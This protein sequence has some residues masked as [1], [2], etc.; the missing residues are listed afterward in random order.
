MAIQADRSAGSGEGP[1]VSLGVPWSS[2]RF[3]I[4]LLLLLSALNGMV[5]AA[6]VVALAATLSA[7]PVPEGEQAA[8]AALSSLTPL[9][10]ELVDGEAEV[11]DLSPLL[12]DLGEQLFALEDEGQDALVAMAAYRD[13]LDRAVLTGDFGEAAAGTRLNQRYHQLV[14]AVQMLGDGDEAPSLE[15][16]ARTLLL[17]LFGWLVLGAGITVAAS[18]RLRRVLSVPLSGLS[19]AAMAVADG[20]LDHSIP[21]TTESQEFQQLGAALETMR[22]GLVRTIAELDEQNA[23]SEAMLATLSDGVLL[24]DR[25]RR[26]LE[27]NPAAARV[28]QGVAPP[29]LARTRNLPVSELLPGLDRELFAGRQGDPVQLKYTGPG[30]THTHLEVSLRPLA[31][32][33]KEPGS[34]FVMVVRDVTRAVEVENLKRGFLSVVTHELKTPLTVIEGYVRLLQMGKGGDLSPKQAQMLQKVRSQAEIL[35]MMV[36]DLLDATR[37]EG[38]HLT[39]DLGQVV[40]SRVVVDTAESL[41]PEAISK[42]LKLLLVDDAPSGVVIH[43][44]EFRF[45]QVL[46]NLLRNAFKFTEPGGTITVTT[47]LGEER[48]I[49]AVRDTGR[50]IPPAAIPKLFEKFYQVEAADTRKAGGAGLG[51]YICEQL[52][53]AMG[54]TIQVQSMVDEGSCFTL[55][56]PLLPP[57]DAG[58]G[59]APQEPEE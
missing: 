11:D 48:L 49:V 6:Y 59:E 1:Q 56:F 7:S 16:R 30:G 37:I 29:E 43:A 47:R 26:V 33:S 45:R 21:V 54:G 2:I 52:T 46:G 34:G 20:D 19:Q 28:L 42:R 31:R 55:S 8:A 41:R 24:L 58:P 4:S 9:H 40:A 39:L 25:S 3:Q 27:F 15:Q 14:G 32:E 57:A 22:R 23:V 5:I 12:L 17:A 13:E 18:F 35:K 10:H 50:G 36:Q 38:G 44:D 51:L 53:R